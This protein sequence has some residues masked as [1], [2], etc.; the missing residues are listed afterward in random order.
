VY[1]V[2]MLNCGVLVIF[3]IRA[4]CFCFVVVRY[5]VIVLVSFMH[6]SVFRFFLA[7]GVVVIF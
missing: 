7:C 1:S 2:L 3:G 6:K 5:G 4:F